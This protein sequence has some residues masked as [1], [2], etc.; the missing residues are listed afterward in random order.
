MIWG[1][2]GCDGDPIVNGI[3]LRQQVIPDRLQG[4]VNVTAR[5]IAWGG[6]PFGAA[7]GGLVAKLAGI[8]GR[9]PG[10]VAASA[11]LGR[12]RR[13]THPFCLGR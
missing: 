2:R 8:P 13:A 6:T 5:M 11:A 1:I 4:R 9:L 10:G 7:L 12:A 3:S